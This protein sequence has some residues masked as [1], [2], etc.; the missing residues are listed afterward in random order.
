MEIP[1]GAKSNFNTMLEEAKNGD[2]ALMDCFDKA[3]GCSVS[4]IC[5]VNRL[6]NETQFVPV[7]IMPYEGLYERLSPADVDGGYVE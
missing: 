1:E 5:V 3:M 6:Q 7:A 4:A 2:L